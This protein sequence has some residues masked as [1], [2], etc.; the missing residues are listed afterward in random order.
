MAQIISNSIIF[1]RN[2]LQ[3]YRGVEMVQK[4]LIRPLYQTG[5]KFISNMLIIGMEH[6]VQLLCAQNLACKIQESRVFGA[7]TGSRDC[8]A[9]NTTNPQ[10]FL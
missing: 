2:L 6:Y 10:N 3:R 9:V 1:F 7:V 8:G 5:W 4:S